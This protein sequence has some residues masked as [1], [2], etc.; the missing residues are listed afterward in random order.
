MK[1]TLFKL[2]KICV[3]TALIKI[4]QKEEREIAA[5]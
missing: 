1:P 4:E 5:R 3:I 2:E